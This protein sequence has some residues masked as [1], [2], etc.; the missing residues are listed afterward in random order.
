MKVI[1]L[2]YSE[3]FLK[4][5]NRSFFEGA[6]VENIKTA[7]KSYQ[8][9]MVKRS[10]RYIVSDYNDCDEQAIFDALKNIFGIYSLSIA[11][12]V[13]TTMENIF[14]TSK[15]MVEKGKSFRVVCNR[16]DKTFSLNSMEIAREIGHMLLDWDE[17]LTVDLH[18][19]EQIVYVDV[20]ENGKT[21]L[22]NSIVK[23]VDG[24][25]VGT[26]GKGLLLLSGGIDS[27]VAGYMMAKRGMVL[28]AVHFHSFPYTSDRAR[29]KVFEL[30]KR[31]TKY[32]VHLTVECINVAEIQT[33][34]HQ[35]CNES[36]TIT[37]LR[38]FMMRIA[39]IIAERQRCGAVI[40]G[41]SL[42]QVASQTLESLTTTNAVCQ[43]PAFR[44]LIGFDKEE[45]VKI[46]KQIDT[47]ETSIEP[48]EDCCTIFL[49][50]SP[51]TRP[52]MEMVQKLEARL[53]VDGLIEKALQTSEIFKF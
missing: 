39:N 5:N 29:E 20:R 12:Q 49:P 23:A 26:G 9:K 30:A 18:N 42:G 10:A 24:M 4:G 50:K 43:L 21:F 11:Q 41:E 28:Y 46:A 52:K 33:E 8:Y 44:P 35:K 14:E 31:L 15:T 37:L 51:I 27:P 36:Y 53:D 45:I 48:F 1:I 6:L 7:L 19:P 25:P 16:A 32:C 13:D 3:I 17:S 34:I 38:R 2:R 40:T 47:Y 22:Y